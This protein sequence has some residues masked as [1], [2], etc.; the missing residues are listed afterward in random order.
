MTGA[1]ASVS[2]RPVVR[3]A[4]PRK[5]AVPNLRYGSSFQIRVLH[6]DDESVALLLLGELDVTS[7]AQF[8]RMITE[9]LSDSP[10]E[11]TFDLTHSQFISAQGYAAIGRCSLEVPVLVRSTTDL[12]SKVMA[13]YGYERVAIAVEG[14][15]DRKPSCC[16]SRAPVEAPP[17][18]FTQ[19]MQ[20]VAS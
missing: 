16:S 4:T 14:G 6:R 5:S 8:E 17:S 12:A 7:M 9:V 19:L 11:L 10:K 3:A 1:R 2:Q 18:R 13:V 20:E 15:P